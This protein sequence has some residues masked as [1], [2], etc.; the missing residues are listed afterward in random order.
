M[1]LLEWQKHFELGI[2]EVDHEHQELI[3][4]INRVHETL[5][6]NPTV[7]EVGA[8]LGEI[9]SLI[10]AHFALEE[11]NM[12]ALGYPGFKEHKRE[13]ESLLDDI[14]DTMDECTTELPLDRDAFSARLNAWFGEHFRTQDARL[15]TYLK[16][17]A[18][19]PRI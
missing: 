11:K 2:P 13:H 9:H 7:E 1:T 4:M 18:A 5:R 12:Q 3:R 10:S 15:H 14:R 8:M 17:S 19:A 16:E 6:R